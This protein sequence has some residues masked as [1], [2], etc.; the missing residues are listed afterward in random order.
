VL[1]ERLLPTMLTDVVKGLATGVRRWSG[2]Q[3]R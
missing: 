3:P 2:D 1:S